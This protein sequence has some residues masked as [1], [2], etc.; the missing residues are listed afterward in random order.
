MKIFNHNYKIFRYLLDLSAAHPRNIFVHIILWAACWEL[1]CLR[2]DETLAIALSSP[3]WC[4][5]FFFVTE[6]RPARYCRL[7]YRMHCAHYVLFLMCFDAALCSTWNLGDRREREKK[8]KQ[9]VG[10]LCSF[11]LWVVF[12]SCSSSSL[13]LFCTVYCCYKNL[14]KFPFTPLA[15]LRNSR[16]DFCWQRVRLNISI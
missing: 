3:F 16:V 1:T 6:W 4:F 11:S 15:G 10:I 8:E 7:H 14:C 2:V 5:F 9:W 13:L 12:L